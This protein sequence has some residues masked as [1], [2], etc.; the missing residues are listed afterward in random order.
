M[1]SD[2]KGLRKEL[3]WK[4]NQILWNLELN[5][6]L[7]QEIAELEAQVNNGSISQLEEEFIVVQ[8]AFDKELSQI[9]KTTRKEMLDFGQAKLQTALE[10]LSERTGIPV[11][12]SHD[13][14]FLMNSLYVPKSAKEKWDGINFELFGIQSQGRFGGDFEKVGWYHSTVC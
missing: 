8:E 7:E 2:V 13:R 11:Y 12:L 1:K 10:E 5:Q 9:L 4:K 6:E 3:E 14:D